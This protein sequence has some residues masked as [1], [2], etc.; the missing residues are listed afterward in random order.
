M[1][2]KKSNYFLVIK[3]IGFCIYENLTIDFYNCGLKECYL[4]L[5]LKIKLNS[6]LKN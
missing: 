4:K 1:K 5:D 3:V 6:C 2:I